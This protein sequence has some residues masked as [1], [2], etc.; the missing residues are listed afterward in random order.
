MLQNLVDVDAAAQTICLKSKR[1]AIILFDFKAA[2]PSMG[3][4]FIWETLDAAGIPEDFVQALRLLYE[5]NTH[6]IR[7]GGKRFPG[8]E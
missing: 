5:R 3:H 2:F 4:S 8:P 1:G 6:S 7:I